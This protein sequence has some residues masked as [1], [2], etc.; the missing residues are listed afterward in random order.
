MKL[1]QARKEIRS[2][3]NFGL[4]TNGE[5]NEQARKINETRNRIDLTEW[6]KRQQ[7]NAIANFRI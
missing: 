4:I 3:F 6:Q 2:M 7:Y 1:T 5:Y